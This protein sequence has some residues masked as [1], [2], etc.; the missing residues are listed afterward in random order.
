MSDTLRAAL[1]FLIN[2]VFDLY[3]FVLVIRLMLAYVGA[4]YFDPLTQFVIR[5]T[6]FLVKPLKR[7]MPNFR[8]IEF[9]TLFLI[10][11]IDVIKFTLIS[12]FS[13]G[14][15]K[16]SGIVILAFADC[17]RMILQILFYGILLQAILSWI[18]PGS[19]MNRVL[20]QIT[21]PIMNPMRRVIPLINGIDISPIPALILLQLIIIIVVNP[22]MQMGMVIA[23]NA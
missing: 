9:A 5:L 14:A 6:D 8:G 11:L 10:I 1:L 15:P 18:Q 13:F 2:T 7:V 20:Y 3:L 21:S 16:F 22:L 17:L 4:N 12:A 23:F 19:Q